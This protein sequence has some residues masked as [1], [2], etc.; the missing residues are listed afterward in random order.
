MFDSTHYV[1]DNFALRFGDNERLWKAVEGVN[2]EVGGII[3]GKAYSI[4]V[5]DRV[6]VRRREAS[7]TVVLLNQQSMDQFFSM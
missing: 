3:L 1:T 2:E 5:D 6:E 7:K 4:N